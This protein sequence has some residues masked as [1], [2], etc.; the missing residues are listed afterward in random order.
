MYTYTARVL[1]DIK[2]PGYWKHTLIGVFKIENDQETQIGEYKRNYP[3][4]YDTFYPFIKDG[5]DY[6][7]YSPHYTGTRVLELPSCNDIGGEEPASNG[8]CPTDF[9]VP[10]YIEREYI[11]LDDTVH[12]YR[13]NEPEAYNLIPQIR[14]YR[15][16]D[17]KTGECFTVEKPDYPTSPL[18]YFSFGF[19]A[20]CYWGD[21]T[22]WKI[23]FLDLSEMEKGI[24]KRDE[25]F[26][27]IQLDKNARLKDAVTILN[28]VSDSPMLSGNIWIDV[29]TTKRFELNT[30]K[31]T[32]ENVWEE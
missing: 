4:L 10:S 8:F 25:R 13:S 12:K 20:G 28:E 6:A 24:I 29:S 17:E 1:E 19:V 23:Q 27:Y 26:G 16:L 2:R 7:L 31:M 14:T 5:K 21:D 15:P 22:R 18:L 9:Y 11:D 30:G 3:R 32:S